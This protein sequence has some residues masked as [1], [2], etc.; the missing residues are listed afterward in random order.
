MII[1]EKITKEGIKFY[2]I[3]EQ[4]FKIYG[5]WRDGDRYY[6]VPRQ[7]AE[8]VSKNLIQ[9]CSQTAGGR[10]RFVTDSSY[11]AVKLSI[12]NIE[13]IAMMTVVG[14]MGLDVYVDGVFAGSLLPPFHQGEGNL[15][16]LVE[17]GS[18][19]KREITIHFPLYSGVLDFYVGV[20]SGAVIEA[21]KPYKYETPVVYYGSS[22]TNGG[23]C[24]RPGMTYEAQV[25]RMLDCNHHNLGFGGSAKAE[26]EIAEYIAGLEMSAFIYDYD[27]NARDAAYLLETHA[28]MFNIIRAK[29]PELP[30]VII[31]RPDVVESAERDARFNAIKKTYDEAIAAGDKN[32]YFIDGSSFF[33]PFKGLGND[34]TV[35]KVHPTDLG[36]WCMA[37]VVADLLRGVLK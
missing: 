24:S 7:V 12:H 31:T 17:L 3:D 14:T 27:Y 36:F 30:I 34:F 21:A 10:V 11:V 23:C 22:I 25:S 1:P 9:K 4:P 13:Q 33:A 20:D 2:S 6:R 19:K 28:R 35:D 26:I 37:N 29:H 32:V 5:V 16:A 18:S 8:T 15:E